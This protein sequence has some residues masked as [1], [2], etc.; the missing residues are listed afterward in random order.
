MKPAAA[1]GLICR[2]RSGGYPPICRGIDQASPRA[3]RTSMPRRYPAST[4]RSG[5]G[6]SG[7]AGGHKL[8]NYTDVRSY[9]FA[10]TIRR[11][12]CIRSRT[13]ARMDRCCRDEKLITA[14]TLARPSCI[15]LRLRCAI[16][17]C[18]TQPLFLAVP[19]GSRPTYGAHAQLRISI[20]L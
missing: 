7:A 18:S 8:T 2:H 16:C 13:Q 1:R 19:A 6:A 5:L 15:L 3:E 9:G 4:S 11:S 20:G 17:A 12:T 10:A 14:P